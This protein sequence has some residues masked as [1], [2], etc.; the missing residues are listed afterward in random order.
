[1][2]ISKDLEL[3][4]QDA[5]NAPSGPEVLYPHLSGLQ[6]AANFSVPKRTLAYLAQQLISAAKHTD[7]GLEA[8]PMREFLELARAKRAF[9][10]ATETGLRSSW[11]SSLLAK[12]FLKSRE[13]AAF[14]DYLHSHIFKK[15]VAE[16]GPGEPISSHRELMRLT[17]GATHY[18]SVD[19]RKESG[20]CGATPLSR[21]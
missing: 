9:Y 5:A 8:L 17:L 10:H 1:M 7:T 4:R 3:I 19:L 12:D 2:K 16:I 18:L 11:W 20:K 14:R 21:L 15:A 6:G 13:S